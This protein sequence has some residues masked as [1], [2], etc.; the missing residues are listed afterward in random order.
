GGIARDH[1]REVHRVAVD[2]SLG[3]PGPDAVTLDA[4]R[5]SLRAWGWDGGDSTPVAPSRAAELSCLD[6][7][8]QGLRAGVQPPDGGGA[9]RVHMTDGAS[10]CR[11]L[12]HLYPTHSIH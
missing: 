3:E 6:E 9:R 12:A 10:P 8:R 2:G 5:C 11:T 7:H 4:H 1:P